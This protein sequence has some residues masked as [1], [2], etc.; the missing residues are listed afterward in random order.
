MYSFKNISPYLLN[1]RLLFILILGFSS[2]LPLALTSSTLQA[3][4]T[5]AGVNILTIGFLGFIGQPYVYKFV[6]APLMDRFEIPWMGRRRGWMLITQTLLLFTIIGMSFIN[7]A[8]HPY[9][10]GFFGLLVAFFSASQDINIDAYR[11]DLL[12]PQERGMGSA[13]AVAGYRV[14][15]LVSGGLALILAAKIGWHYTYLLMGSLMLVG[16][17]SSVMAPEPTYVAEAPDSMIKAAFDPL[18]DLF[19]RKSGLVILVFIVIYKLSYEFILAMT[20]TFLLRDLGFTLIQVGTISKGIGFIALLLGIFCGG[21]LLIRMGVL[22]SLLIFGILQAV[23]NLGYLCLALVG[24]DITLLISAISAENFFAGMEAAAFV[25]FLMSLCNHKYTAMQ[26]ALLSALATVGRVVAGPI[27][28]LIVMH[29]N[30]ADLY[31]WS[32]AIAIPALVLLWSQRQK[33]EQVLS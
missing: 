12:K 8:Q 32:F 25:A 19:N 22:R 13:M 9:F 28:A 1:K 29:S 16:M 7:P 31:L 6:W 3:W 26:F 2:G 24:K 20:P 27:G 10:L 11:T 15:M 17:I 23:G 33:F 14:A 18:K 5:V 4:Y 21:V 30:W